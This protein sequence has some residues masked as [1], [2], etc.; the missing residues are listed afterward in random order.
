MDWG[1][2]IKGA[3]MTNDDVRHLR[4]KVARLQV[5]RRRRRWLWVALVVVAF[6]GMLWGA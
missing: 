1:V 2:G 3:K 4:R 5:M 6:V